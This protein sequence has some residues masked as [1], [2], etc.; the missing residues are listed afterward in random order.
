MMEGVPPETLVS[1]VR[2]QLLRPRALSVRVAGAVSGMLG[3]DDP[4]DG[5]SLEVL[6]GREPFEVELLLSPLFTP[7]VLDREACE[8]ALPASGLA[9]GVVEALVMTL[10]SAELF[11]PVSYGHRGQAVPLLGVVIER[12]VRLL[13]LEA[14]VPPLVLPRLEG[15]QEGDARLVLFSLARRPV[16]QSEQRS[17]LLDRLLQA[18]LARGSCQV[19]KVRFLTDFVASYRPTGERELLQALT[20]LVDAYHRDHEH[21]I[22]NQQLEHYQ[23]GNIRSSSCGADVRAYRLAMAHALLV[24]LDHAPARTSGAASR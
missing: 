4:L 17:R 7:N 9:V 6:A 23:G 5:L 2:G 8:F 20:N 11:C 12:Y 3:V 10:T 21:P 24:D 14:P 18:M 22:Y 19:D 13:H 1:V 15:W 16:W